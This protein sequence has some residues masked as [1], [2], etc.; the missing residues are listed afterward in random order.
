MARIKLVRLTK[1]FGDVVAADN[2]N[3]E[4]T[5]KEFLVIVGPSGCGKTTLL[6][7]I[8]GLEK[9]DAGEIYFDGELMN[10]VR[11]EKRGVHMI[12]QHFALWPHMKVSGEKDW[13]NISFAMKV[14]RWLPWDIARRTKEITQKVGVEPELFGR[15]PTELSAGQQQRVALSRALVVPPRV[16]LMDEPMANLDAPSRVKVRQEILHLHRDMGT[17]TIYVTHNM[18]DA[19]FLADRIA[20]MNDG[21]FVQVAAPQELWNYPANDF[22]RDFIKAYQPPSRFEMTR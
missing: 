7:L 17:T 15:K 10:E 5:D 14:R 3:I 22:V 2:V 6:R 16:L 11:V 13:S 18:A 19:L 9:P 12:F 21:S 8:A 4:V 1:R 20:V